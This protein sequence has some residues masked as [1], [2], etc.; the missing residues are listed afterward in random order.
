[1]V[2]G[3]GRQHMAQLIEKMSPDDR[4]D[5]LRRLPAKVTEGLLRLVD[6]ADRRDIAPQLVKYPGKQ[7]AGAL[8]TT[9]YAWLP[10][11]ISVGE[12]LDRLRLQAPDKE[13]IYYVYIV[14]DQRKLLGVVS[15]RGASSSHRVPGHLL[16]DL[17]EKNVLSA[18]VTDDREKIAQECS[19]FDLLAVPV[20]DAEGRLVGIIT[21][22]D[23][24]DVVV[25]EAT[26]DVHRMGAGCRTVR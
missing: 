16:Q 3:T 26:E 24:M 11:N 6:E 5:L 17:M 20:V 14:D 7:R 23:I 19:R 21:Y 18:C 4:A 1:M 9:D 2:E 12:A 15:L 25:S 22:D 10:G 13:T 8:M